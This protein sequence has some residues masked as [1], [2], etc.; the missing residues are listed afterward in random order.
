MI[1]MSECMEIIKTRRS[2]RGFKPDAQIS[3]EA[4][5]TILEAAMYAPLA[6]NKPSWHLTVIQSKD[7]FDEIV[8]KTIGVLKINPNDHVKMRLSM[9]KFS[10]FYGAPTVIAVTGDLNNEYSH[11][12]S[13]AAIENMLLAAK[14][15]GVDSC[16]VCM[17]NKFLGSAEGSELLKRLGMPD[18]YG[19]MGCVALGYAEKDEIPMPNKHFDRY[20]EIINFIK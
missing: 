16:W 13:G 12:N 5:N 19:I 14:T 11:T 2:V 8:E 3:D 20:D 1:Y 17:A 6:V 4:L 18:G 10:P 7:V 15:Q 9:P